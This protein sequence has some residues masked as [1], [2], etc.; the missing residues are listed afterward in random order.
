M[1]RAALALAC[2]GLLGCGYRVVR[3]GGALPEGVQAVWAPVFANFTAEPGLEV[4]YTQALR[5]Q[6]LRAGALGEDSAPVRLEGAVQSV[7]A[8]PLVATPG[9]LSSYRVT[10][11]V[12]L[13]LTREGKT[14]SAT[15]VSGS[16]DYLPGA[17]LLF[18]EANRQA[19]LKR[20][21]ETMMREGYE[22]LTA[23]F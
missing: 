16:E 20:L 12:Q 23:G 21:A 14:L 10:A 18:S 9:R 1:R 5:E 2:V 3:P 13:K 8:G 6:L 4:A 22:R 15:T 11:V 17:D 19:A 7:S